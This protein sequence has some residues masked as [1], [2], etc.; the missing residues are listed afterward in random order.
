M[1]WHRY[2]LA[3][4]VFLVNLGLLTEMFMV[5]K[6]YVSATHKLSTYM[7]LIRSEFF[8]SQF[9]D[10]IQKVGVATVTPVSTILVWQRRKR[11]A[12]KHRTVVAVDTTVID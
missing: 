2:G 11:Y 8:N 10:S 4:P 12:R 1:V 6:R 7:L 3:I 5:W 9:S